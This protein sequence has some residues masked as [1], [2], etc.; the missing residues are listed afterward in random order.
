MRLEIYHKKYKSEA[1]KA[2]AYT[3]ICPTFSISCSP[4]IQML[5]SDHDL[6]INFPRKFLFRPCPTQETHSQSQH[7]IHSYTL[8]IFLSQLAWKETTQPIRSWRIESI[9]YD[10]TGHRSTWKYLDLSNSCVNFSFSFT[11]HSVTDSTMN[12][13]VSVLFLPSQKGLWLS[14]KCLFESSIVFVKTWF[15]KSSGESLV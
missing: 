2:N 1:N 15:S 9:P 11:M 5:W 14:L 8:Y 7:F 3:G 6:S 4:Q 12:L 10:S 13:V